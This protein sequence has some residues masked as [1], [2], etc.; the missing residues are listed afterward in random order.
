VSRGLGDVYKRQVTGLI[1]KIKVQWFEDDNKL[2]H[3]VMIDYLFNHKTGVKITKSLDVNYNK[4]G[5]SFR[6]KELK[7][8]VIISI[9]SPNRRYRI[10]DIKSNTPPSIFKKRK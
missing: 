6:F 2:I 7:N 1:E 4:S 8:E 10:N 5:Y 3:Y 9:T